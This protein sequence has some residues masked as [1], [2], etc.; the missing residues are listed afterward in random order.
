VRLTWTPGSPLGTTVRFVLEAGSA[1][2]LANLA[3]FDVG[4][5]ASLAVNGVPPGTYYVRVRSANVTGSGQPSNE[6]V[7]TCLDAV[8]RAAAPAMR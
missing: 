1:P 8:R 5:P 6:I 2:G 3:T 4:L 7:V